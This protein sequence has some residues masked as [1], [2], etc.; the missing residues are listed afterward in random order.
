MAPYEVSFLKGN[1]PLF[2]INRIVD[3]IFSFD[4]ILNF[5]LAYPVGIG[6]ARWV[7]EKREIRRQYLRGWFVLDILSTIPGCVLDCYDY[8]SDSNSGI[9]QFKVLRVLR[10]LRLVKLLR[11]LRGTRLL[12]RWETSMRL[13]Y[14]TLS[15]VQSMVMVVVFAHWS[16]CVWRMQVTFREDLDDTWLYHQSYCIDKPVLSPAEEA[17]LTPKERRTLSHYSVSAPHGFPDQFVCMHPVDIYAAAFYWSVMTIT[18]VG[19]GD[20]VATPHQPSEQI[21]AAVLILVGA[22]VWSHVV[23]TFCGIIAT[24]N[25]GAKVFRATIEELNNYMAAHSFDQ[26]MR[27]RLR[28]Y[29]HRTRHLWHSNTSRDVLTRLSP[30]LQREVLLAANSAWLSQVPWLE[31]EDPQFL[32]QVTMSMLPAVF[33]PKEVIRSS[34]LHVVY[35]GMAIYGGAIVTENGVWGEDM[36]LAAAQLRDRSFARAITYVEVF[37]I[38]R[39]TVLGIA[40]NFSETIERL[41]RRTRFVALQRT[42]VLIAKVARSLSKHERA[43]GVAQLALET[44]A[45]SGKAARLKVKWR[46]AKGKLISHQR[47]ASSFKRNHLDFA[48]S[49]AEAEAVGI[50]FGGA[51]D[52]RVERA[53]EQALCQS[54]FQI[55]VNAQSESVLGAI[56]SSS[57]QAAPVGNVLSHARAAPGRDGSPP[58]AASPSCSGSTISPAGRAKVRFVG[59]AEALSTLSC[60][61]PPKST[62]PQTAPPQLT[63]T[64]QASQPPPQPPPQL[65][66][67]PPPPVANVPAAGHTQHEEGSRESSGDGRQKNNRRPAELVGRPTPNGALRSQAKLVVSVEDG[68]ADDGSP[69]ERSRERPSRRKSASGI[70]AKLDELTASHQAMQMQL[71][72]IMDHLRTLSLQRPAASA[73]RGV[74]QVESSVA[75]SDPFTA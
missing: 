7:T 50:R 67:Q 5:F 30:A 53:R 27:Q 63:T 25:P 74:P 65:P 29:F 73:V 26:D 49:E 8:L 6:G 55:A 48:G 70:H 4:V 58:R 3:L 39:D 54:L 38:D 2:V 61:P 13:D 31:N 44:C 40:A 51:E 46:A 17:A 57:P 43:A 16:A 12:K 59:E 68:E 71:A 20:I 21:V 36:L 42:I 19:Y 41:R 28:D 14:G 34:A 18:S 33:A 45:T 66:P 60:A 15:L 69:D 37:Y 62:P 9:S 22:F 10:V 52:Q 75:T 72:T 1:L 64:Q 32:A 11:L 24:M 35:S 23:G 47:A 56:A